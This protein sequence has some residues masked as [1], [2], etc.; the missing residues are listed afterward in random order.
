MNKVVQSMLV[1]EALAMIPPAIQRALMEDQQY[2]SQLGISA[3]TML[4]LGDGGPSFRRDHL[5]DGIRRAMATPSSIIVVKDQATNDWELT[6]EASGDDLKCSVRANGRSYLL[7]HQAAL[8][9][10]PAIRA[11]WFEKYADETR[12]DS[13]MQERWLHRLR[14]SSLDDGEFAE[15][16]VDLSLTPGHVFKDMLEA[17]RQGRFGL[18]TIVPREL[19]YYERL[20]G[21][22]ADPATVADYVE[23]GAKPLI[24]SLVNSAEGLRFA[25]LICSAGVVSEAVANEG[26]KHIDLL[27]TLNWVIKE[28]DPM[29]CLATVEIGLRFGDF[30]PDMSP[31]LGRI[32]ED[33]IA[34]EPG[35]EG[36]TFSLLSSVAMVV[37]AELTRLGVLR[38]LPPFYRRQA[39]LAQSSLVI[40]AIRAARIDTASV[41]RWASEADVCNILFMQGLLD[42]VD[43]PRWLPDFLNPQQLRSEFIGR[44]TQAAIKYQEVIKHDALKEL[45]FGAGSKLTLAGDLS[46]LFP[47]PLEGAEAAGI[48]VP[49]VV[50]DKI[51]AD[52]SAE[53][54]SVGSFV[55]LVNS[56]RVYCLPAEIAEAAAMALRKH[57]FCV[58]G[59]EEESEGSSLLGGLGFVAAN[60]RNTNLAESLRVLARVFRRRKRVIFHPVDELRFALI[61]AAAF[62]GMEEWAKFAGAWLTEIAFESKDKAPL[63]TFHV[64][65]CQLIRLAPSLAKHCA[66]GVA[67]VEAVVN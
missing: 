8:S 25:L 13:P 5:F 35:V 10:D 67:A 51:K 22:L 30:H 47:G 37:G 55:A 15:L 26:V 54:L 41:A 62:T 3:A 45:L 19:L 64:C 16:M 1:R 50:L 38:N 34:D 6:V 17:M 24:R 39:W 20:I 23:K 9:A 59:V 61:S 4:T 49:N 44:I 29:S 56:G 14:Q 21:P 2:L 18:S 58:N 27:E 60:T 32:V 53:S 33:F 48:P 42:L 11:R 52:L 40:R 31:L 66:A 12:L 36:G 63:K 43:E 28:G 57:E 65:L 7:S 46:M